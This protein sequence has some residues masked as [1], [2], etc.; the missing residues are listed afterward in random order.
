MKLNDI[1]YNAVWISDGV[2]FDEKSNGSDERA[3]YFR[4]RFTLKTIDET[5]KLYVCGLG[6]YEAKINGARVG[7]KVLDPAFT[8]YS[9]RVLYSVYDVGALLRRGENEIEVVVG[10]GWYN[11]TTHDV[12]K[13]WK[14]PWRDRAKL[15]AA[16]VTETAPIV[17]TDEGWECGYGAIRSRLRGGET[18][19]FTAKTE[20]FSAKRAVAPEGALEEE[21]MPPIR[22]CEILPPVRS[23]KVA[24][25]VRYDFG[26]NISGYCSFFVKGNRGDTVTIE[27]T[28]RLDKD[29][30]ADNSETGQY[31]KDSTG[32]YQTDKCVLSGENDFY[33]P[34]FTYHGFRYA[35][36]DL[37]ENA[38]ISEVKAYFVHTDLRQTGKFDCDN[39]VL[40]GLYEMSVN[41]ILGNYHGFPSDCPH[42]EKNGWTGDGYLSLETDICLFEMKEAY[43]K[44]LADM[45]DTQTEEGALS[46]IAPA[47]EWYGCWPSWEIAFYGVAY[48]LYYY[49]GDADG[50][51]RFY[52]NMKKHFRFIIGKYLENG[53][54]PYG[55]GD[56]N[57]PD[58]PFEVCPQ[59]LTSSL[60]FMK[61]AELLS[62]LAEVLGEDGTE[63]V[64][65]ASSLKRNIREKYSGETSLTGMA[66]LT[67]FG[68]CDKTDEIVAYLEKHDYAMHCGMLGAKYLLGA[69]GK[70][71]KTDELLRLLTKT[72]YPSFGYWYASG[73][74]TLSENF[75]MSASLNHHMYSYIVENAIRYFVGVKFG[76]GRKS[77]IVEP[78]LPA[79]LN[80]A[81]YVFAAD[82]GLFRAVASRAGNGNKTLSLTVPS[83]FSVKAFGKTY[84]KGEY[85]IG[86]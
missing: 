65:A 12:W 5:A 54:I 17:V 46:C 79:G 10:N 52:P 78:S 40:N 19:D 85:V 81:E 72:D 23:D 73:M 31:V 69:L 75:E 13:F 25:R 16:I 57:Y 29:G 37:M 67:Y 33:K 36:V 2:K 60:N 24:G 68:V 26:K 70:S 50:A 61:I 45:A 20:Y 35:F 34:K 11:Q 32:P 21:T 56:L 83:G 76:N 80:R 18:H 48:A 3:L 51:K 8:D 64:D 63:Y 53:L 30:N 86:F 77:A 38:K 22:E 44:W 41:S 7:D 59:E 6:L 1:F 9:K 58:V 84:E 42:R 74:T 62:D 43:K 28:D 82:G 27:Y 14:K 39:A 71:G 66:G 55:Q 47:G 15:L 4:K 49:Y